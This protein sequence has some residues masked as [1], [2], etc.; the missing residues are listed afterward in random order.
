MF[1]IGKTFKDEPPLNQ[2]PKPLP[3]QVAWVSFAMPNDGYTL[4]LSRHMSKIFCLSVKMYVYFC[5]LWMDHSRSPES[6]NM[7]LLRHQLFLTP[8]WSPFLWCL[9]KHLSNSFI[10]DF[11]WIQLN[12]IETNYFKFHKLFEPLYKKAKRMDIIFTNKNNKTIIIS[13]TNR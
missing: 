13:I 12:L 9:A 7:G 8:C 10:L 1:G 6:N 3:S 11:K 5:W 2:N 4:C